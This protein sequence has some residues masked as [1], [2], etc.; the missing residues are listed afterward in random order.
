MC[1][2]VS[3][4]VRVQAERVA[5]GLRE[6]R[7]DGGSLS[8]HLGLAQDGGGPGRRRRSHGRRVGRRNTF[9]HLNGEQHY[10]PIYIVN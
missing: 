5:A 1:V 7:D 4:A 9:R 10:P 6:V 8:L 2:C 3:L